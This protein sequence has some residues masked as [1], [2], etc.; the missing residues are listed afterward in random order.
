MTGAR[1]KGCDGRQRKELLGVAG[2]EGIE[3]VRKGDGLVDF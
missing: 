1:E 3:V 2:E